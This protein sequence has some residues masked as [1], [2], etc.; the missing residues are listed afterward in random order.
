[1]KDIYEA[2]ELEMILLESEDTICISATE[3]NELPPV[4]PQS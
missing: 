1:M 3:E 4:S 2:P